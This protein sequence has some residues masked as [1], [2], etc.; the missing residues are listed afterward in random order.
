[1]S[2][3]NSSKSN[4]NVWWGSVGNWVAISV[5][6]TTS[7]CPNYRFRTLWTTDTYILPSLDCLTMPMVLPIFIKVPTPQSSR[8]N[9]E[10]PK[11]MNA[12]VRKRWPKTTMET[13]K[14][15]ELYQIDAHLN[16]VSEFWEMSIRSSFRNRHAVLPIIRFINQN[17]LAKHSA[18]HTLAY[19]QHTAAARVPERYEWSVRAQ[20]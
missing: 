14:R 8:I 3:S 13:A 17:S 12:N 1:M 9:A 4:S 7:D 18:V 20:E 5:N 15:K 16:V 10:M 2:Y 19:T 11:T 6:S